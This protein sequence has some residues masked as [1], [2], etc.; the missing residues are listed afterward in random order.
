MTWKKL[1]ITQKK[2]KTFLAHGKTLIVPRIHDKKIENKTHF[3]HGACETEK[4]FANLVTEK[5]IARLHKYKSVW[6]FSVSLKA[7]D[8]AFFR[9]S[10]IR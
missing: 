5:E 4:V 9:T 3:W 8:Q 10:P 7:S 6:K 2:Y 1:Q